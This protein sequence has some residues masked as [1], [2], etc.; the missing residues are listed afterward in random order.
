MF[1]S[2]YLF[3]CAFIEIVANKDFLLIF[4]SR[5]YRTM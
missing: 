1:D 3:K 2:D 4:R 5:V